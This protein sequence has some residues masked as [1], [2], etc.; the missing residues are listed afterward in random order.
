MLSTAERVYAVDKRSAELCSRMSSR[1]FA[2]DTERAKEIAAALRDSEKRSL[3]EADDAVGRR[4]VRT[5]DRGG[6]GEGISTKD[7]Q[8]AFFEDLKA[9]VFFRSELTNQPSLGINAMRGYAASQRPELRRL[10]LAV[11]EY[12]RARKIRSTYVEAVHVEQ[13]GRVHPVWQNYGAVS[14]RFSCADPNLMNLPRSSTDPTAKTHAGGV[15]SLY[16]ARPG[17]RLVVF[18]KKQLEMRIAAYASGDEAMIA[19]CESEDLHSSNAI[20]LFGEAFERLDPKRDAIAH[21]QMRTA[22]KSAG[23]AVCYLAEAE[24]VYARIVADG[25]AI[26][27]R[28]VE[29]M[30]SRLKRGFK[31][32]YTWQEDR[33]LRCIRLGYTDT[34]ILGRQRWLGHEPLPTECANFP[35]QG[36]AADVMNDLLPPLTA[37]IEKECSGSGIVAQVHDSAVYE[38]RERDVARCRE[39]CYDWNMKPIAISSSGRVLRPVLG[40]D[41]EDAERWS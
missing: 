24:T 41:L 14:G 2:F 17:Y 1:G 27:L 35:I 26:T 19:T 20:I 11:L 34:P 3:S 33:L 37:A 29:A 18:D 9:P 6:K 16:R 10:A 40:I 23:F 38:V 13:D 4:I 25:L 8:R 12:R 36:G 32:Y 5:K 31:T 7:L 22:A 39:M 28:Q 30:L 15:R 21:K